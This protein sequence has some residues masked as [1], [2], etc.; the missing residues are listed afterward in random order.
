[1]RPRLTRE[2]GRGCVVWGLVVQPAEAGDT[3]ILDGSRE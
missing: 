3:E 1:M 2:G